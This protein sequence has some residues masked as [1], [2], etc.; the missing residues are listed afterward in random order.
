MNCQN[1]TK[2]AV[3]L[4]IVIHS[5]GIGAALAVNPPSRVPVKGYS[6]TYAQV[7]S[8]VDQQPGKKI[9]FESQDGVKGMTVT[10]DAI[11]VL[12]SGIYLLVAS[13]QVTALED[14]GCID[15][16]LVLNGKDIANSGVRQCQSTKGNT[17]VVVSQVILDLKKGDTIQVQTNGKGVKLDA[18]QPKQGAFIPS[19]IFT[20]LGLS[21]SAK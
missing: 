5:M 1:L 21:T 13:P 11:T 15:V 10:K 14:N 20:V 9:Q 19:I 8:L 7:S 6:T 16:W 17:N 12:R 18:I 3:C 2:L 4:G